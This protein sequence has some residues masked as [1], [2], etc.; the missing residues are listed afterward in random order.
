MGLSDQQQQQDQWSQWCR[1]YND[2]PHVFSCKL[3]PGVGGGCG[4]RGRCPWRW[5]VFIPHSKGLFGVQTLGHV[6]L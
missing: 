3:A 1:R 6:G 5:P 2:V 4:R